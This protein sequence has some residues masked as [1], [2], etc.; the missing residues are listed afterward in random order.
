[1]EIGI[2]VGVPVLQFGA[3]LRQHRRVRLQ[4]GVLDGT[5][6]LDHEFQLTNRLPE[7]P[8]P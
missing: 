8:A 5:V 1:M 4:V 3:D 7:P 2:C 6:E